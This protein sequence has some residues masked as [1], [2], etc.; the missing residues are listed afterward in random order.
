MDVH[1]GDP[2]SVIA[3]DRAQRNLDDLGVFARVNSA[4]ENS[5]GDGT[6]TCIYDVDEAARYNARFGVGAE[7]AQ[8][9]ASTTNLS[10]PTSGTGFS[11][12]FLLDVDRID[13]LGLG[14]TISFDGRF[15]NLEQ[16]AAL[17]YIIPNFLDS[18]SRTLTFSALYDLSSNVR[19]FTAKREEASVQLSQKVSRPST[20]CSDSPIGG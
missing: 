8:L 14:H 20:R 16:R 18:H 9:G 12:R 6:R 7:I 4:I 11:P 13:F 2:L 19:T 1:A 5:D 10:A 17:N 3:I 15:S